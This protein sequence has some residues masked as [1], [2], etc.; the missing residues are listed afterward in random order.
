MTLSERISSG[1]ISQEVVE[2][3][4]KA[5]KQAECPGREG[6]YGGYDYGHNEAFYGKAPECGRYFHHPSDCHHGYQVEYPT[7]SASTGYCRGCGALMTHTLVRALIEES[8]G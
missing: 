6:P 3:V 5:I 8:K 2:A 4:A 7:A 1:D